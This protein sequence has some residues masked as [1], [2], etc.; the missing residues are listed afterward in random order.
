MSYHAAA[1]TEMQLPVIMVHPVMRQ[2]VREMGGIIAFTET[3]RGR[4]FTRDRRKKRKGSHL[5]I[6]H[7]AACC[8]RDP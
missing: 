1:V 4:S 6:M 3:E 2:C 5:L 7:H 8:C